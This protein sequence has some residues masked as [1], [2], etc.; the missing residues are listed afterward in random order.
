MAYKPTLSSLAQLAT[1]ATT[2]S[3]PLLRRSWVVDG[4]DVVLTPAEV[5]QGEAEGKRFAFVLNKIDLAL[6]VA[7]APPSLP[8]LTHSRTGGTPD[9]LAAAR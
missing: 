8:Q 2:A 9:V 7:E 3:S 5:R 1:S 6:G 4:T